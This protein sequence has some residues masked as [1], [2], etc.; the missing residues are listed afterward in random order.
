[1]KLG[2]RRKLCSCVTP[3]IDVFADHPIRPNSW[4]LSHRSPE[5][6][7]VWYMPAVLAPWK[8][9]LLHAEFGERLAIGQIG[10]SSSSQKSFA[11]H[12]TVSHAIGDRLCIS[13]FPIWVK[14]FVESQLLRLSLLSTCGWKAYLFWDGS[15]IK[16]LDFHHNSEI[17]PRVGE[18]YRIKVT[19]YWALA[20]W[21]NG[22]L[23]LRKIR[24]KYIL[25]ETAM[26]YGSWSPALLFHLHI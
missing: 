18:S 17:N 7:P 1:M 3:H 16:Y 2:I 19:C 8:N 13:V 25:I 10:E 11:A 23:C 14:Y 9:G 15:V 26:F 12:S 4:S 5:Y 6:G 24:E 22:A 20:N 21:E